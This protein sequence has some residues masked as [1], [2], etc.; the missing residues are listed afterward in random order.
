MTPEAPPAA[1][2]AASAP[3]LPTVPPLADAGA[4]ERTAPIWVQHV[5]K[6]FGTTLGLNDVT[7]RVERGVTALVGPNG[8]GKSTLLRLLTGQLRP[9]LGHVRIFGRS[10]RSPAARRRVGYSP[11]VDAFYEDMTGREFVR[12]MLRLAGHGAGEAADRA[13]RAL[14]RVGMAD[15]PGERRAAKR[16]RG[17]S[18]GM[19]QRVR[20][21]QALAHDPDLLILDEP[22]SG[23]DPVG[24]RDFFE[25]FRGLA[26]EGKTIL[27]SSHVLAEIRELADRVALIAKGRLLTERAWRE[28][29]RG[30]DGRPRRVEAAA[31]RPRELAAALVAWPGALAVELPPDQPGV[32]AVLTHDADG[33]CDEIG[34]LGADG[35]FA[36]S[37]LR[38][39][40]QWTDA[41]FERAAE[42]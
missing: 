2:R 39:P 22:M 36:V 17:C 3:G 41:L 24:R 12:A 38:V 32:V 15:V 10:P 37:S 31:D 6:W 13:E 23:M 1:D 33:C 21:A 9:S 29:A 19:R 14:A 7:F 8:A 18:K 20:L 35:G 42:S 5:S 26:A 4:P 11:D 30:G 40:E 25:L 27:V 16:L 28:L 34:R